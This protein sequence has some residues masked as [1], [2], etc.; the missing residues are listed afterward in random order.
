MTE[1]KVLIV[2]YSSGVKASFNIT[3][4]DADNWIAAYKYGT[5]FVCCSGKETIGI[6]PKLV[7]DFRISGRMTELYPTV[8][9]RKPVEPDAEQE[10]ELEPKPEPEPKQEEVPGEPVTEL[11]GRPMDDYLEVDRYEINCKCGFRGTRYF[12]PL[13]TRSVCPTCGQVTFTDTSAGL[14][15]DKDGLYWE[16]VNTRYVDRTKMWEDINKLR[17][18]NANGGR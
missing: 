12:S 5:K 4:A 14:K 2:T 9:A 10:P 3:Q 8:Q 1:D 6:S 17:D 16:M 13:S 11:M 18:Y 7:A 15:E